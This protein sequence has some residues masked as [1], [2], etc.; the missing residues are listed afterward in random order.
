V[1]EESLF[2]GALLTPAAAEIEH[3]NSPG[4]GIP[5]IMLGHHTTPN[6]HLR[7]ASLSATDPSV[8]HEPLA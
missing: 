6:G 2:W 5:R 1:G 7:I 4:C 8:K 3:I